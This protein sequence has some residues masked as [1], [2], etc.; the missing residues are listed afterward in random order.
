VA[1]LDGA[2]RIALVCGPHGFRVLDCERHRLF[3]IDVL[4]GL[5]RGDEAFGVKMLRGGNQDGIDRFIVEEVA[6]IEV[7]LRRGRE[8]Q[9]I[10]KAP[11]V[12]IGEGGKLGILARNCFAPDLGSAVADSDHAETYAVVRSKHAAGGEAAGEAGSHV[13]DEIPSGLHG[14]LFILT[15]GL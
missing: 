5:E 6:V 4:A 8:F 1:D 2:S 13:P 9:G 3:L 10:L 7:R 11:R 12:D 15:P 14:D